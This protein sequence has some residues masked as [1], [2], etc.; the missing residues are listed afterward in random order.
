MAWV[1]KG[2]CWGNECVGEISNVNEGWR[3]GEQPVG[4]GSMKCIEGP[5][6]QGTAGER[7]WFMVCSAGLGA[8]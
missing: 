5:R 2:A 7:E 4:E 8:G 1:V 6:G 3:R